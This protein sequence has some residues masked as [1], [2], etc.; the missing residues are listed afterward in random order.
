MGGRIDTGQPL[1]ELPPLTADGGSLYGISGSLSGRTPVG[2]FVLS[3]GYVTGDS[4]QVQF[5]L[6][7]PISEGSILDEIR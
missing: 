2:P 3:V 6:G 1:P 4:W 5:A 7:R